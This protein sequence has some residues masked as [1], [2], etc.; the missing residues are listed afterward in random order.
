MIGKEIIPLDYYDEATRIVE[1]ISEDKKL[2]EKKKWIDNIIQ[3]RLK[4]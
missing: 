4:S 1:I 3:K 2:T